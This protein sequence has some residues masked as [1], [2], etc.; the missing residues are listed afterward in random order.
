MPFFQIRPRVDEDQ[1]LAQDAEL[2]RAGCAKFKEKRRAPRRI[3]RSSP[4]PS[5]SSNP[6]TCWVVKLYVWLLARPGGTIAIALHRQPSR[7]ARD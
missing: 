2:M 4:R 6:A 3:G 5:A 1:D 7:L